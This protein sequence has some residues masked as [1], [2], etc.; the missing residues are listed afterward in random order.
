M[1]SGGR[2]QDSKITARGSYSRVPLRASNVHLDGGCSHH[3]EPRRLTQTHWGGKLEQRHAEPGAASYL[4]GEWPSVPSA[5]GAD[6]EPASPQ[7]WPHSGAE[8]HRPGH[9]PGCEAL[10][11]IPGGPQGWPREGK[12]PGGPALQIGRHPGPGDAAPVPVVLTDPWSSLG[13]HTPRPSSMQ[14]LLLLQS[15]GSRAHRLQ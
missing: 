13:P 1:K 4:Q 6:V 7:T 3:R 9:G 2:H 14:W 11:E 10:G 5:S 15:M 12:A 8:A